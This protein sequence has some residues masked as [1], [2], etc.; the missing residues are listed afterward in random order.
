MR[1]ESPP[2]P[3]N[4]S[5]SSGSMNLRGMFQEESDQTGPSSDTD[6]SDEMGKKVFSAEDLEDVANLFEVRKS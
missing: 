1:Y 3:V 4:L 2:M 5:A 6:M